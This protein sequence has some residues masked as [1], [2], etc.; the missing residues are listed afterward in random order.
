MSDLY[1]VRGEEEED[2]IQLQKGSEEDGLGT[3]Q[4]MLQEPHTIENIEAVE[5]VDSKE[6]EATGEDGGM[7]LNMR[8]MNGQ[9]CKGSCSGK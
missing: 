4:I 9:E 7:K 6:E 5:D 1:E 3:L 8:G 2:Q